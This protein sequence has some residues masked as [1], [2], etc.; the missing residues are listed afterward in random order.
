M[1]RW[2]VGSSRMRSCGPSK[3][4]RPIIR[5]AF[6]PPD[7]ASTLVA[8]RAPE[9]PIIAA[10][11]RIFDSG[12]A[13]HALGDMVVDAAAGLELVDLMLGEIADLKLARAR[14]PARHRLEPPG[15]QFGEGRF[16]V[17]VRA[18]EADAVV[19]GEREVDA[20]RAPPARRI[21]R[22]PSPSSRSA[23]SGAWATGGHLNGCTVSSTI[24]AIGSILAS[25]LM[26]DWACV[27]FDALARKRSTKACKW[28]RRSSCFLIALP[29]R[30]CCSRRWRS[31]LE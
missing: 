5:R 14:H 23:G 3:A 26:R 29:A 30:T 2:L 10:R 17:A 12:C 24:A 16:A 27:A 22:S 25:I 13:T 4:A 20:R 1:S 15:D 7:R 19:V 18:E 11:P 8:A 21:R 9:K 31:K 6:S 28:A